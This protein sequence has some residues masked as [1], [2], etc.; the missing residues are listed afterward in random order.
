MGAAG[1]A[2]A[3]LAACLGA[4]LLSGAEEV[5]AAVG[6]ARELQRADLV[7]TGEGAADRTSVE[8]KIVGK[9][10][11]ESRRAGVP[12]LVL[13]GR[14]R[15]GWRLL[16]KRGARAVEEIAPEVT[17][18]ESMREAGK[19]LARAARRVVERYGQTRRS[20]SRR[21]GRDGRRD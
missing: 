14:R 21:Q 3:G 7:L 2:A 10:I 11:E 1:G 19:F 15:D 6:F 16:L 9:V 4:R 13:T 18:E 5:L 8:G 17:E 12:V 20:P